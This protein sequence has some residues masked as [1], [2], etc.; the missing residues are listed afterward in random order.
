MFE[1]VPFNRSAK[2]KR[3]VVMRAVLWTTVGFLAGVF[4][5]M[6]FQIWR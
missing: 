2:K 5:E 6:I 1:F 4:Y 3:D